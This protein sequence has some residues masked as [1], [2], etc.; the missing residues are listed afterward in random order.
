[1]NN[2]QDQN[3]SSPV[4]IYLHGF[5]SSP[6]SVK[7]QQTLRY[8]Q[9]HYPDLRIEIP[10]IPNYP[11]QAIQVIENVVAK[12]PGQPLRFIGSSM[13]GFLATYMLE[14]YGGRAVLINPAVKPYELFEDFMGD[15]INPYTRV[16]F[17]LTAEHTQ[18]LLALDTPEVA[19]AEQYWVLLQ[20][21]DETLDYR[22]AE[23][24]Y[25][26]SKLTIEQ[27]G[28]HSFQ[29]YERHLNSI[30]EFLLA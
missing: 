18:H 11:K 26:H 2:S 10:E 22:Q 25:R 23:H 19:A 6:Q 29:H 9:Q 4:L 3:D 24:K 7:A 5:L 13:G 17:T 21:R 30:L 14:K 8:C 15:H 27:G 16:S 28:D 12:Y 20:T 1:M